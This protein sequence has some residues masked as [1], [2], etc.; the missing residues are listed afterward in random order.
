MKKFY[1]NL[2][3]VLGVLFLGSL[4]IQAQN[5]WINE[6]HYDND[7]SDVGEFLEIVIENPGSYALSDFA[8][9]LYNGNNGAFYDNQSVDNFTVGATVGD[10]TIYYWYPESIQNGAPDGLA[11][12]YQGIVI[13]GQ[14]LSYEGELT[15]TD[16]PASGLTSTDIGVMEEGSTPVGESLQLTGSGL[17]YSDFSWLPPATETPGLENNGQSFGGAFDPE[18]S[19]YPTEFA[20]NAAGLGISITWVDATGDQ[21]PSGYLV[22]GEELVTRSFNIPVDGVPVE[23]DLDWSD[24]NVSVNV[25]NGVGAYLF[26]GLNANSAYA[27]TIYPYTN[28]GENIN[29]KTDGT[30]PEAIATTSNIT[31]INEEGFDTELSTWTWVPYNVFGDQVW[32]WADTYGN[33]PGCAKMTGYD[34]GSFENE[35]WLISPALDLT[36]YNDITF[37]FEQARNYESNDGLFVKISTDYDGSSDPSTS[38][39][40][41]DISDSYIWHEGGWD[42]ID[43][44]SA[45]ISA[46]S[47]ASTYIAFIFTSTTDGSATWELD[48]LKVLGVL[49]TGINS[50]N[51]QKLSIYPN[52]ASGSI[53]V[54][55]DESGVIKIMSISGKLMIDSKIISGKNSIDIEALSS[56]L[57]IVETISNSGI[58][59]IGKLTV[60]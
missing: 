30:A 41:T 58:K 24:G 33:P 16:G 52:P 5:A 49:N 47:S 54:N 43:A 56:G 8:V 3:L 10:F 29:Y 18:P 55:S 19:N 23:N 27:F 14:F 53:N 31:V 6:L 26:N 50:N 48:N 37:G 4:N 12:V 13:T 57:Y 22:L 32:E 7:G 60:R 45:D 40:W 34:G 42:F 2:V 46:Y 39:T 44:G 35:D 11:L 1:K 28:A 59:S 25:L 9:Y 20:A 36:G 15:A 51:I 38:G 21:I 17:I